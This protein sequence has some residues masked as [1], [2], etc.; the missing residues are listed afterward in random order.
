MAHWKTLLDPSRYLQAQ[1][2]PQ[3]REVTIARVVREEL[4]AREGEPRQSAPMLYLTG[5]DGKEYTRPLKLAKSVLYGMSCYLGTDTDTWAGKKIT[6]YAA[7][8][9]AFG[10]AEDCV[11]CQFPSEIESKIYTWLKKRRA[12]RSA[13]ILRDGA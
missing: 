10:E 7:R 9:L 12:S 11:R 8:C 4:P 5:K 1:D 13:Y 3:P 6:L 2:F